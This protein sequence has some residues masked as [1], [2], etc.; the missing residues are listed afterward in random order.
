M[1]GDT[2][3]A[4]IASGL[5][6]AVITGL[7]KL[8]GVRVPA[9]S[10]VPGKQESRD[11][12]EMGR[13]L[14]VEMVLTSSLQVAGPRLR[15]TSR[16]IRVG[17][18]LTIWSEHFDGEMVD[19][20]AMQDSI[21]GKIVQ[22]IQPRLTPAVR[23]ALARSTGT[24]DPE[25]YN[26]YMLGRHFF[27]QATPSSLR[28]AIEHYQRAFARDSSYADPL[29]E[30]VR[31]YIL[32]ENVEPETRMKPDPPPQ[33]L[34]ARAL[35]IDSTHGGAHNLLALYQWWSCNTTRAEQGFRASVRFAPGSTENRR[36]YAL[37]LLEQGRTRE[38]VGLMREAVALEPTS[39][40]VLAVLAVAYV[41][42]SQI[43]S[44]IAV[45]ERGF[46]IDST[47]W[48]ANAV[49]GWSRYKKG[50]I[51]EGIRLIEKAR[52]LGGDRHSLT[53][54]NLGEL[55]ARA[56]RLEDAEKVADDLAGR[57]GRNEASRFD[58]AR[59]YVALGDRRRAMRAMALRPN[60]VER[61]SG[62]P[63]PELEGEPGYKE[64]VKP[65]CLKT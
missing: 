25:A 18:G 9:T 57:V 52:Q 29:V 7:V 1:I 8:E 30:L 19:M 62:R 15:L 32:I 33:E 41:D 60:T 20:F 51:Q 44:A 65:V 53:I 49:L 28:R 12:R 16:L 63:I 46:G 34:L 23:G 38:A 48:V 10:S 43:D 6:E 3:Q 37:F 40:W 50:D 2:S 55:Y 42:A 22:A 27:T 45:A 54:G 64:L 5:T 24:R 31:T 4:H 39:P 61:W 47:N 11:P 58:L 17:D 59:V 21:T 13:L 14:Q 56:G 35:A 26:L 36:N